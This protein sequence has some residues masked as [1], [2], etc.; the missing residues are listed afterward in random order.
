MDGS[1]SMGWAHVNLLPVVRAPVQLSLIELLLDGVTLDAIA[2]RRNSSEILPLCVQ[3]GSTRSVRI[4]RT[5]LQFTTLHRYTFSPSCYHSC[6]IICNT[7]S[8]IL[9]LLPPPSHD[10][11]PRFLLIF[12]RLFSPR[13]AF[14]SYR[15]A[16][17]QYL[18]P[19]RTRAPPPPPPPLPPTIC[20]YIR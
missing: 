17:T 18:H 13:S 15:T 6:S 8:I 12:T 7:R 16:L 5:P 11:F 19:T 3:S 14:R 2:T 1:S 4:Q 9:L 10:T 20:H